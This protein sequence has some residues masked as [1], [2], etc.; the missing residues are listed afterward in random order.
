MNYSGMSDNK[1]ISVQIAK[2]HGELEDAD[3]NSAMKSD[4]ARRTEVGYEEELK[5]CS[6][7]SP[8]WHDETGTSVGSARNKLTNLGSETSRLLRCWLLLHVP[9]EHG[10]Q[11]AVV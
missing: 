10:K 7:S 6:Y 11:S 4:G 8:P 9:W 3:R 5:V 2:N 1:T